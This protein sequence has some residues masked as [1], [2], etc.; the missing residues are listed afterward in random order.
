MTGTTTRVAGARLPRRRRALLT[1]GA[2]LGVVV[3]ISAVLTFWRWQHNGPATNEIEE[4]RMPTK[5]E[6][7]AVDHTRVLFGHQSVGMNILDGVAAIYADAGVPA[8]AVEKVDGTNRVV[9]EGVIAHSFIGVN[10]DPLGK[11][12]AFADLMDSPA[13]DGIDV[14][15]MKLCYVDFNRGTDVQAVFQAYS[16]A[17]ARLEAAHPDVTFLYTTAPLV[18][19]P[20]RTAKTLLKSLLGRGADWPADNVAR[21]RYNQLVRGT[22][23]NTGRLFDIAAIESSTTAEPLRRTAGGEPYLVLHPDLT[24]DGGHLNEAGAQ[25]VASELLRLISAHASLA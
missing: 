9:G 3:L 18:S 14:A 19:D 2:S 13:A 15:L 4:M 7:T 25:R 1:V 16:T 12:R 23:A 11:I 5:S 24:T 6:L 21:E 20:P 8:P 22:Y 10:G 17:M